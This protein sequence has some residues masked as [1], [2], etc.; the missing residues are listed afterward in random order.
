[1]VPVDAISSIQQI[2]MGTIPFT[3]RGGFRGQVRGS[4]PG[5]LVLFLRIATFKL[6]LE[7][8]LNYGR[9]TPTRRG[10]AAGFN[11]RTLQ[12]CLSYAQRLDLAS[13]SC[14]ALWSLCGMVST[15][16]IRNSGGSHGIDCDRS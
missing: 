8:P 3:H 2:S 7:R 12:R 16:G 15:G 14:T 11:M 6:A 10:V 4:D 13:P 9:K 5:M 1:V